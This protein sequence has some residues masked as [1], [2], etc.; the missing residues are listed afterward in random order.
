MKEHVALLAHDALLRARE[1]PQPRDR[2]ADPARQDLPRPRPAGLVRGRAPPRASRRSARSRTSGPRARRRARPRAAPT[3]ARCRR[4]ARTTPCASTSAPDERLARYWPWSDVSP[5]PAREARR[6]RARDGPLRPLR[7]PLRQRR[8]RPPGARGRVR[9]RRS[10][11][12]SACTAPR[13]E[14]QRTIRVTGTRGELRGVLHDGVIEVT[15][16]GALGVERIEIEGRR[17]RPLRRRRGAARPLHATWSRAAP[18]TRCARRGACPSRA[19]CWA[20]PPSAR[21]RPGTVVDLAAFRARCAARAG[22]RSVADRKPAEISLDR[23]AG[24][25]VSSVAMAARR[26]PGAA[27]VTARGPRGRQPARRGAALGAPAAARRASR[28]SARGARARSS[29]SP[30][31]RASCSPRCGRSS[32]RSP[33]QHRRV[34]PRRGPRGRATRARR[35]ARLRAPR[36]DGRRAR[37]LP[38][39]R[40]DPDALLHALL[41]LT[42]GALEA[43]R[44]RAAACALR[45][46]RERPRAWPSRSPT[47]A[48]RSS[49]RRRGALPARPRPRGA[50]RRRRAAA[51]RRRRA[52]TLAGDAR[53]T[54]RRA[55]CVASVRGRAA[56]TARTGASRTKARRAKRARRALTTRALGGL[57]QLRGA[58]ARAVQHRGRAARA[59]PRSARPRRGRAARSR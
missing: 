44:R 50:P 48:R 53:G 16:H 34:A 55:C 24:R 1:V 21:G 17:A 2:G 19:T 6:A 46:R 28:A 39:V 26:D 41:A 33:R 51:G 5:D 52:G 9:G 12:A 59:G 3:A 30:P 38:D 13:R 27:L 37:G 47:R 49:R 4:A 7:V 43:A 45:A 35:R 14:E 29:S 15:R 40:V 58:V 31:R 8:G 23:I 32:P 57:A 42:R 22:R 11:R 20:S 10:P 54:R 18:G 25:G 56:R 36:R